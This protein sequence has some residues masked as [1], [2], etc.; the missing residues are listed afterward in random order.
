MQ[1][2]G[3]AEQVEGGGGWGGGEGGGGNGTPKVHIGRPSNDDC[4]HKLDKC[5]NC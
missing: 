4:F 3:A 1:L 2:S 5:I